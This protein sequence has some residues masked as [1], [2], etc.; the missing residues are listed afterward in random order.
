MSMRCKLGFHSWLDYGITVVMEH[1]RVFGSN[2]EEYRLKRCRRC[3]SWS[4]DPR[5]IMGWLDKDDRDLLEQ[6]IRR[7]EEN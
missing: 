2:R 6:T 7:I 5:W 4:I 1:Y 3:G